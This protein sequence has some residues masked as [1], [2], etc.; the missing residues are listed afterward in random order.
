MRGTALFIA[1][2]FMGSTAPAI[3]QEAPMQQGYEEEG[4]EEE[5]PHHLSLVVAA[6]DIRGED[7]TAFTLGIDYEYRI[8]ELLGVGFVVEHAFGEVDST[9][10]IA[11]ADIHVWP[12]FA[13]QVGPGIE[14]AEG[15][16]FLMGRIGTVYEFE[17]GNGF[18]LAPQVHYD[19]SEGE[20]AFVFGAAF[21]RAF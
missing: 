9:T 20:D 8:S 12:G 17:L 21:G 7:E 19:F 13:I 16:E 4:V 2:L 10:L 1:A 14:F 18:T 15:E 6:T 5:G 3:A 11:A